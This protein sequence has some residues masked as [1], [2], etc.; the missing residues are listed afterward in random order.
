MLILPIILLPISRLMI[1]MGRG[2]NTFSRAVLTREAQIFAST[3]CGRIMFRISLI[4]LIF[5]LVCGGIGFLFQDNET[6]LL[7]IFWIIVGV[8]MVLISIPIILTEIAVRR[9]FDKNGLPYK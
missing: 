1:K 5:I 4:M 6:A 7:T 8:P 9:R 3:M 2:Y